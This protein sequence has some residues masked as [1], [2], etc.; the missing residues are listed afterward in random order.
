MQ[1]SLFHSSAKH[2]HLAEILM[3]GEQNTR[4]K[5]GKWQTC[6]LNLLPK[7]LLYTLQRE[8]AKAVSSLAASSLV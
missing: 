6:G 2:L 8:T 5:C 3:T 1:C 7:I 4:R